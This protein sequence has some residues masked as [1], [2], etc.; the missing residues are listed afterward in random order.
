MKYADEVLPMQTHTEP[1]H[2]RVVLTFHVAK[3]RTSKLTRPTGD[4]DNYAKATLDA[5]TKKGFWKDDVDIVDLSATK[6]FT[7]MHDG[8]PEPPHTTVHI[9]RTT[10]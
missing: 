6:Q 7:D 10:P 8:K 9:F 1:A 2:V 5:L 4:I 3:A